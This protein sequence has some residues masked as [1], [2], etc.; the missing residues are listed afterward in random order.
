MYLHYGG[1]KILTSNI[2]ID[3]VNE[4][5]DEKRDSQ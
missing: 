2:N 3:K 5:A 1:A 4:I